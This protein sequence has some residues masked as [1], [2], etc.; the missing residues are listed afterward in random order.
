MYRDSLE[1][2]A[3]IFL[4]SWS[5]S[6][7]SNTESELSSI[8]ILPARFR[9]FQLVFDEDNYEQSDERTRTIE[10]DHHNVRN[11]PWQRGAIKDHVHNGEHH[12]EFYD[13]SH[14]SPIIECSTKQQCL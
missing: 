10:E 4:S 8:L 14:I 1:F 12:R 11:G 6:G 9:R 2:E 7:M 3:L 5:R 13:V